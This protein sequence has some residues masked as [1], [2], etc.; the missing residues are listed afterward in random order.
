MVAG[1]GGHQLAREH[2]VQ[3]RLIHPTQSTTSVSRLQ[4]SS[5]HI[6]LNTS[7]LDYMRKAHYHLVDKA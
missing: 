7:Y 6:K 3:L 1:G 5:L 2:T 4:P